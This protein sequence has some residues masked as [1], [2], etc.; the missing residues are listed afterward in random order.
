MADDLV[1][2]ICMVRFNVSS[3]KPLFLACGHTFCR[4]CLLA[5]QARGKLRCPNCN[6]EDERG[7]DGLARNLVVLELLVK[8][9]VTAEEN[10]Q[11][12][13]QCRK[14]P[15]E[16]LLYLR[17]ASG[18]MVCE[19]CAKEGRG[20]VV[21]VDERGR[22]R[23]LEGYRNLYE[24]A[25]EQDLEARLHFLSCMEQCM[26]GEQARALLSAEKA[27]TGTIA[28]LDSAVRAEKHKIET[29]Y[30][31]Q[32]EKL[33]S[34][35]RLLSATAARNLHTLSC[36]DDLSQLCTPV[37][38]PSSACFEY[39]LPDIYPSSLTLLLSSTHHKSF[40]E[41]AGQSNPTEYRLS[42]FSSIGLRWGILPSGQQVEALSFQVYRPIWLTAIGLGGPYYPKE[43]MKCVE[44]EV[45]EGRKSRGNRVGGV[46]NVEMGWM[47]RGITGV[48]VRLDCEIKI[49]PFCDYT[50]RVV[51]EGVAGV[52]R[53][54]GAVR[55]ATGEKGVD[56]V[57]SKAEYVAPDQANGCNLTDGPILELYYS[58]SFH[59]LTTL[60]RPIALAQSQATWTESVILS[61]KEKILLRGVGLVGA[62]E[63]DKP[64]IV[65]GVVL[66]CKEKGEVLLGKPVMAVMGD[67]QTDYLLSFPQPPLLLPSNTYELSLQLTCTGGLQL[68]HSQEFPPSSLLSVSAKDSDCSLT[69]LTR[70]VVSPEV[71]QERRYGNT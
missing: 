18:E 7:V 49:K 42:R 2:S 12:P 52:Y 46:R 41:S 50:I 5:I 57:F 61:P 44:L 28:R 22:Q 62:E 30:D 39:K 58:L 33:S 20:R 36:L 59:S 51:F 37:S 1:C 65:R 25:E 66:G 17:I 69:A 56:F 32:T 70:L 4:E 63:R 23:R 67:G 8:G 24:Q 26:R 34:E 38:P 35:S 16:A 60:Y 21:K 15:G 47:E 10:W 11:D 6:V 27:F 9:V 45:L 68:L 53:G 48:K 64:A 43:S 71:Q 3:R 29:Y 31:V 40:Q 13:W 54:S 55:T 14:H 19:E